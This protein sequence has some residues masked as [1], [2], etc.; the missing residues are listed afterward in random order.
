MNCASYI[1]ILEA[2]MA[3]ITHAADHGCRK[4]V[5][6]TRRHRHRCQK[7]NTN[8]KWM[9]IIAI[10][11]IGICSLVHVIPPLVGTLVYVF[12][13]LSGHPIP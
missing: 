12:L 8:L 7:R 2:F 9:G 3:D 6:S 13:S 4:N 1:L 11:A 10:T 5:I